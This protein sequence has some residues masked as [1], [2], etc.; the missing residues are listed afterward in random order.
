MGFGNNS[1]CVLASGT[2]GAFGSCIS[3]K[4]T[5]T[6]RRTIFEVSIE[7]DISKNKDSEVCFTQPAIEDINQRLIDHGTASVS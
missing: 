3:K 7:N 1:K 4:V 5:V 2:G 6:G